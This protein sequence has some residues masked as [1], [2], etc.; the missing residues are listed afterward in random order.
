MYGRRFTDVQYR[1]LLHRRSV[2]EIVSYLRDETDY[3]DVLADVSPGAVHRQQLENLLR[4][5]RYMQ[6]RKLL[7]YDTSRHESYYHFPIAKAEIEQLLQMIL[8][9]NFNRASDYITQYPAYLAKNTS[10]S[11]VDLA[12]VRSFDELLVQMKNTPYGPVLQ[13]CIPPN[14]QQAD[15]SHC[16]KILYSSYITYYNQLAHRLY[17][18]HVGDQL[19]EIND[20]RCELLN[21]SLIYRTK[22][23]YPKTTEAQ[24]RSLMLPDSGRIPRKTWSKWI[25]AP[26]AD[27]FLQMLTASPYRSYV[28]S[29]D[30]VFIEYAGECIRYHLNRRYLQFAEDAPAAFAAYMTLSELELKNI[31]TIVE[32]VRYAVP[33]EEIQKL[34]IL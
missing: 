30:F 27:A 17:G 16:E 15:L 6:Y 21:V 18:K 24:I 5:H 29:K 12:R 26:D 10:F 9:L 1:A 23:Y 28:G 3:R 2:A 32:G 8:L 14:A 34:L 20:T 33:S 4:K 11:L 22:R 25:A 13:K 31:T 19:A 7:R